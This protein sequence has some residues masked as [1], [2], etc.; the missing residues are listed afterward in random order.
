MMSVYLLFVSEAWLHPCCPMGASLSANVLG[1]VTTHKLHFFNIV[2]FPP[3]QAV[4]AQI[5]AL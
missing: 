5:M 2:F 4:F 3:I 1:C